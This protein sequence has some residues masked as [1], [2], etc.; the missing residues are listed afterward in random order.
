MND[1]PS[2]GKEIQ[3]TNNAEYVFQGIG[4][5]A[6]EKRVAKKNFNAYKKRYHIEAFSDFTLLED[7]VYRETLQRR[8]KMQAKKIADL[9]DKKV[10]GANVVPSHI[11]EAMNENEKHML[12]LK[13]SLG[14]FEE[15]NQKDPYQY[16]Q[17]L[18]RKFEKW[19]KENQG[20]RTLICPH[21]SEMVLL[22]IR[23][24]AWEAQKHPFFKDRI[25]ANEHLWKLYKEGKLTQ[26]DVAKILGTAKDYT[27]WLETKIYPQDK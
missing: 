22:K 23:T 21:C 4:L 6:Q 20:S 25:L 7:L 18:K 15:K 24:E 27:T 2:K 13:K 19:R 12:E 14:L 1:N 10:K 16:I 17:M 9:K 26:D 5:T 8:Y 11:M 3:E